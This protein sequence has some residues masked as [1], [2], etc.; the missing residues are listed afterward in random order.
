MSREVLFE[1]MILAL[2]D[3][4]DSSWYSESMAVIWDTSVIRDDG[5][6]S[7]RRWLSPDKWPCLRTL[8]G[9]HLTSHLELKRGY[10]YL[11]A[12]TATQNHRCRS[13]QFACQ[14]I[15]VQ[16]IRGWQWRRLEDCGSNED[17]WFQRNDSWI[18][19]ILRFGGSLAEDF[20]G[21]FPMYLFTAPL[22][23][24]GFRMGCGG[25]S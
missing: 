11:L 14:P 13:H 20:E 23:H 10:I 1:S 4:E 3:F 19:G 24:A 21:F 16:G 22:V 5:S 6:N 8:S 17:E 12:R 9:D 15:L 7:N 18:S 25:L 2:L